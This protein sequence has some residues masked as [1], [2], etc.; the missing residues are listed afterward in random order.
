MSG[1]GPAGPRG[2]R[3]VRARG[4]AVLACAW[5]A[6]SA[7][8]PPPRPPPPRAR[9]KQALFGDPALVPTRAGERARQELAVAASVASAVRGR[10][11]RGAPVVEVRLP[12]GGDAGA[13]VVAGELG[14][15]AEEVA[16]VAEA[17]AGPWSAGRVQVFPAVPRAQAS[18]PR[19]GLPW[20]LALALI[21]LGASA[22]VSIDRLARRR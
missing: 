19:P 16:R 4:C 20:A 15:D 9:D 6:V 22:G 3:R 2:G 10:A 12:A 14:L 5:L 17:V 8:E 1:R 7:C 11:G 21:G 18:E 13:V